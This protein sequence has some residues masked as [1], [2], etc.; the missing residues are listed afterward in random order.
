MSGMVD[1]E[2]EV[3]SW[4]TQ[5]WLGKHCSLDSLASHFDTLEA[6]WCYTRSA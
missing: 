4:T 5:G 6:F 3:S 1:K 2:M